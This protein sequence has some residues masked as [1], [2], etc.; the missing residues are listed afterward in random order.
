MRRR[1]AALSLGSRA[2]LAFELVV[3]MLALAL[4]TAPAP[5]AYAG[6]ITVTAYTDGVADPTNC[7]GA[8]CR[9]RD[10]IAAANPGDE[11][12]FSSAGHTILLTQGHLLL[13]KDV[14]IFFNGAVG[15]IIVD[16]QSAS[17]A[18]NV[19]SGTTAT[20]DTLRI[21]NGAAA[22][23]S[24][25]GAIRVASG[26]NLTLN[27]V[28]IESSKVT[29]SGD[30]G[31]A[32]YNAGTLTVTN[33]A[34]FAANQTA[35]NGNGGAIYNDG[36]VT[37]SGNVNSDG[38]RS[39][40]FSGNSA[41]ADGGAIY[42]NGYLNVTN[43]QIYFST[44]RTGGAIYNNAVMTIQQ[45]RFV[46]N[47]ATGA[48]PNGLGGGIYNSST[49]TLYLSDSAIASNDAVYAGGGMTNAGGGTLY[50]RRSLIDNNLISGSTSIGGG[51]ANGGWM[52]VANSTVSGNS[53]RLDGGGIYDSLGSSADLNNVTLTKNTADSDNDGNGNGGGIYS[54]C[55][56]GSL[57][58]PEPMTVTVRNTIIAGNFDTPG[59][60]GIG[61]IYR[62][63]AGPLTSQGYN[64][65]NNTSGCTIGGDTTGNIV[66]Q[67]ASLAALAD[68]GGW[69]HTF[70]LN[71]DSPA[72]DAGNPATPG[73][74]GDAC[75]QR[76][77][78][79]YLRGGAA[80]RCDIGAFERVF[81]LSLPAIF[82]Q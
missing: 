71:P 48:G 30:L 60:G 7:P 16:P 65:I 36:T 53:A 61:S 27:N 1:Q 47:H 11:I 46:D 15:D 77:Q 79:D 20:L 52:A 5:P 3:S 2:R 50:I 73:S 59:N 80:G 41:T 62:D 4:L 38:T 44:A 69:T 26:A 17:R 55:P 64:L 8:G 24:N 74:G 51:I 75:E 76:D 66:G 54:G 6:T 13:N 19:S 72:I 25:G 28:T 18:F 10:A 67:P 23:G 34:Y 32:I 82:R 78:R 58:L 81:I 33:S 63:C 68:N 49:G 39:V 43:M 40:F 42:N 70:A 57:C 35:A 37:L 9:L 12:T 45:S 31:G 56:S 14:T 22:S 29:G 21:Q